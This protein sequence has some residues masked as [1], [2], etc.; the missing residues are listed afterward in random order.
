MPRYGLLVAATTMLAIAQS[1]VA[2]IQPKVFITDMY[3]DEAA[4]W[5]GIPE[6]D[7]LAQNISLPGLSNRYPTVHCTRDGNICQVVCDEGEINAAVTITS[8]W[9]SDQFDLTETYWLIAGDAGINPKLGTL[10]GV[11]FARF[12]VQVALQYEFDAREVPQFPTGYVPQGATAPGQF[13]GF[14][15]G[16]EVYELNDALRQRAVT[17]AK[18]ATL[19]DTASAQAYRNLYASNSAYRAAVGGPKVIQCD[20]ATS[21]NWFSGKLLSTAFE[22]TTKLFTGGQGEY[23][24]TEQEDNAVLGSLIRGALAKK[25]DFTRIISM[26]T[27]SDFDR[28]APG[29]SATDNLF[30]GQD[31]GYSAAVKNI[32]LAGVKVVEDIVGNWQS[33]Y[34]SGIKPSNY[35]GDIVGTLGP[36]PPFVPPSSARKRNLRKGRA[37]GR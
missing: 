19:N 1:T 20:T 11:A 29:M 7:V 12:A 14:L 16:T 35:V 5:Y 10:G 13:P 18:K 31:A 25:V 9:L 32:Y 33:T 2:K 6:F 30:N 8:L 26:R 15:Y 21:D 28:E 4:A 27:G 36:K 24:T 37:G 3:D 22:N 34:R 17:A 23:C